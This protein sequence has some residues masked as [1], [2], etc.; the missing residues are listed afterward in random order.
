MLPMIVEEGSSP[1]VESREFNRASHHACR[2]TFGFPIAI[3]L[4][5]CY[6]LSGVEVEPKADNHSTEKSSGVEVL[7]LIS[8]EFGCEKETI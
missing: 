8:L 7:R 5:R 4:S 6:L 1:Q 3:A 2:N